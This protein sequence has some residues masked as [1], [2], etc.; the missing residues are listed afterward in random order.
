MK[1]STICV[2][3]FSACITTTAQ[4]KPDFSGSWRMDPSRSESAMHGL[5][6]AP[7]TVVILQSAQRIRIETTTPQGKGTEEFH[8]VSTDPAAVPSAPTAKWLGD[9]LVLDVVR[10]VRG[11]SVTV[12]ERRTLSSNGKEMFVESTTNVQHGYSAT[13]AKVYGTG[14]DVFIRVQH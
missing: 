5:P 10:N 9:T 4:T 11:Q 6:V 1:L 3:A 2:I 7:M 12:Q 8:F 14:K 13:G